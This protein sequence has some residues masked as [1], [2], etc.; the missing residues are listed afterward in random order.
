MTGNQHGLAQAEEESLVCVM[1]AGRRPVA[2][3]SGLFASTAEPLRLLPFTEEGH[4][5]TE[6]RFT[7]VPSE[8]AAETAALSQQFCPEP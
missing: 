3:V 1:G 4:G 5:K 7:S 8:T 6:L 2:M